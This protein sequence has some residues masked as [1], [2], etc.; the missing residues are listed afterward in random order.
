MRTPRTLVAE[1]SRADIGTT[2]NQYRDGDRAPLLRRRLRSYLEE[3][4][5]AP[6]LL[7][8]EAPGYRGARVSGIPFASE[9]Q[10]SGAGPAEATATIVRTVLEELGLVHGVLAWNVVPTHPGDAGSNR[11]P[12]AGEIA[13]ASRFL[14]AVVRGRAVVPVGRVAE[15]ALRRPGVRHPARGGA[16]AFREELRA[17]VATDRVFEPVRPPA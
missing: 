12:T 7:V 4:W 1:L 15:A 10:L 13:A 2:F 11:R 14:R 17:F 6:L 3:R 16:A 5:D 9:R 8:G